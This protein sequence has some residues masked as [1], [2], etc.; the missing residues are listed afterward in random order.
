VIDVKASKGVKLAAPAGWKLVRQDGFKGSLTTSIY[1]R[2]ATSSEPAS[3]T[4]NLSRQASANGFLLAVRGADTANPVASTSAL[5]AGS[6]TKIIGPS[7][8][9]ARSGDLLVGLFAIAV[10]TT[11]SKP[12]G[13]TQWIT[14]SQSDSTGLTTALAIQAVTTGQT[15]D[16][17]AIAATAGDNI[18]QLLLLRPK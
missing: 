16:R 17:I 10:S 14:V 12:S 7:V 6:S 11:V 15:G 9:A 3:Y 18:G 5:G 1:V 13:M 2:T 4:F 8:S